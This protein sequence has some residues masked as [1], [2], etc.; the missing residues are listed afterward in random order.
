MAVVKAGGEHETGI[1]SHHFSTLD[2]IHCKH[3]GGYPFDL[4][5]W[6]LG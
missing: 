2:G 5:H 1:G 4:M 6:C 3:C